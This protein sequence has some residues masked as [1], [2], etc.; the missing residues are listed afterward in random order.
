MLKLPA[1]LGHA[2]PDAERAGQHQRL[3]VHRHRGLG[4][5]HLQ[6]G[7]GRQLGDDQLRTDH[8]P[9]RPDPHHRQH[10][11][12]RP[13]SCPSWRSTARARRHR[14]HPAERSRHA[15]LHR[16]PARRSP[17]TGARRPTTPAAAAWPATTSTAT[18]PWPPASA[19]VTTWADTQPTTATVS[20]FVRARD[21]A[22]NLSG[23]SNTV[24]RTGTTPDTTPPTVPGTLSYLVSGTTITLNWGASTDTGGS[25]LAGYNVY[26]DGNLI[27]TLGTVLTYNDTQPDHGD[28][29]LLRPGPRR[30][31]QPVRQQQHRDPHRHPTARLHQRRRRQADHRDRLHVHLR[32][33]QRRSTARSPR[34]GRAR[35]ATRRT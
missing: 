1:W 2:Q 35:R 9:V 7:R 34:T 10:A 21:V 28:R 22:G 30:R 29:V 33:D 32:P 27:A 23:N 6:P 5:V 13:G 25:G 17:S 14:H 16:S 24:T 18:A 8:D 12:G 19:L 15:V 26:R 11:S 4:D 3:D 31:R 20:Y